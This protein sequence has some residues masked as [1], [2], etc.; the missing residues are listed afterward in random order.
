MDYRIEDK[1][2]FTVVG[3]SYDVTC[4]DGENLRQI[5]MFWGACSGDGTL[6]RLGALAAGDELYG[7]CLDMKPDQE[8]F[9][10]MIACQ[11][12]REAA[13]E[14][15]ASREIA[16]YT[17]AIFTSVGLMPGAIQNVFGRVYQEW[18]PATGYEHAGGPEMEVYPPGDTTSED[19][20]CEVWVPILKK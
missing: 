13:P 8:T 19:Y 20:R 14:G 18:F 15:F 16:G 1:D 10:Y 11:A 2:A 4:R 3:K 9:T 17:W 7:I 5:P 12:D 6:E